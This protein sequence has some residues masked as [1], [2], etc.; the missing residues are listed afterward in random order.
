LLLALVGVVAVGLPLIAYGTDLL[1][2]PEGSFVDARFSIRGSQ[3]PSRDVVV[4]QIDDVTFDQLNQQ[5]PFPRSLHARVIDRLRAAGARAIAYDVQFTE[6]T[7]PAQ[8]NA[9][10]SAVERAGNVVLATTEV[11]AHGQTKVLGGGALLKE[12]GARVGNSV[13]RPDAGGV[14]RRMPYSLQALPNFAIVSAEAATRHP[15]SAEALPGRSA[16]I[17]YRGPPG[18]LDSVSFSRVLRGQVDPRRLRGRIAVVGASAPS[19]QDLHPVPTS[20]GELMSGPE[21]EANQIDT[22]LRGFPLRDAHGFVNVA[23]IVMLG[24]CAPAA[25]LR[26]AP[27]PALGVALGMGALFLAVAQ[28]AFNAGVI[29]A[30]VYP[31]AALALGIVLTLAVR[32]VVE[33]F[34][35]QRMRLLFSR[36]VPEQVVDEVLARTDEDLRLGGKLITG[37]VMFSDI[38]GFTT[39]A[40]QVEP[41]RVIEALNVY[42]N[43]MTD[44]IMDAGGTLVSYMGDGIMAVF[45]API[46]QPDHADRALAAARIMAQERLRSFNEWLR[47]NGFAEGFQIGIGIHS[48]QFMSGN[49]GS[50]RR[51]DYTV[52]GDTTNTAARLEGMTK[53]S[54]HMVFVSDAAREAL[55]REAPDLEF[56]GERE[57]RGRQQP[58]RVWALT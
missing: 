7:Q 57:V 31:I 43:A 6:P 40:E 10:I 27:L 11:G 32:Y 36:F 24:L 14:I 54:G 58:I 20:G 33:A 9:L 48:G 29:V 39:F 34:A 44:A 13:L 4:V 49:I 46:D 21:I 50:D 12:I 23:F 18:T 55:T 22:V 52:I 56:V 28:L 37:T 35:R 30:V 41:A 1:N 42:L 15:V 5:W 17:D 45:G 53:G 38:R 16:P 3:G 8:D 19:L 25:S 51:V 26:L 2:T 47:G